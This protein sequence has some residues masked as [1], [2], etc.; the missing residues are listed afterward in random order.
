MSNH[1]TITIIPANTNERPIIMHSVLQ[2]AVSEGVLTVIPDEKTIHVY[3]LHNVARYD[4]T[5]PEGIPVG[6]P[7]AEAAAEDAE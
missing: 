3:P 6:E 2:S 7:E 1:P 4:V 5:F